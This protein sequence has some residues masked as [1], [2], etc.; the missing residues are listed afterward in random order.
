LPFNELR[1]DYF[2]DRWVVIATERAKRPNDFVKQKVMTFQK[3]AKCPMCPGN[4][5]M[6][7]PAVLVYLPSTKGNIIKTKDDEYRHKDW[8]VRCV[9]NLYPAFSA[10]KN[11]SDILE[12]L[13]GKHFGYAFGHHEVLIE[14]PDHF[15]HPAETSLEQLT[16]VINAYKDRLSE[17]L[18]KS[19]VKY[20]QI[21]RNH[22]VEAGASQSHPHSQIITTPFT[23]PNISQ[24]LNASK[25]YW[26][27]NKRCLMCSIVD[28][29]LYTSRLIAKNDH[30]VVIAPYAS[31]HPLEFWI[32]PKRH[33]SSLI[34]LTQL[35]TDSLALMLK[36]SLRALKEVVNDPP[37]NFGFHLGLKKDVDDYYHWSLQVYPA[38]TM[39]A[40]FEKSTGVYI[41][42]V[43]PETAAK[44][45]RKMLTI[46]I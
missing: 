7:P 28:R 6:T 22:G 37:Y 19:Y 38:L 23:P 32:I 13:N 39:W 45:L 14:S 29:E 33:S 26:N 9:P 21:F 17:L 44:E 25:N 2:M 8:L 4:E 1:K 18:K 10:P 11:Q 36:N 42:T 34:D 46:H 12:K 35:E 5:H 3:D 41:N 31:V 15:S 30:F 20:V 16:Y 40:G 24:E 43:K 27:M